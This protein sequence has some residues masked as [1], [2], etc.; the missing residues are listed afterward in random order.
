MPYSSVNNWTYG[1]AIDKSK[2]KQIVAILFS[3]RSSHTKVQTRRNTIASAERSDMDKRKLQSFSRNFN[4]R[5]L[6]RCISKSETCSLCENVN[7]RSERSQVFFLSRMQCTKSLQ[8]EFIVWVHKGAWN[9]MDFSLGEKTKHD[10]R[11]S[12]EVERRLLLPSH[13]C[14]LRQIWALLHI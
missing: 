12:A 6:Y 10:E 5:S 7:N 4:C 8:G 3:A 14:C 13:E 11:N 1:A 2:C 9:E